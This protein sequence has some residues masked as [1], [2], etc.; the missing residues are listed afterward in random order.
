MKFY[1][2]K[3]AKQSNLFH[4]KLER[5][6]RSLTDYFLLLLNR[7][8]L[9]KSKNAVWTLEKKLKVEETIAL[10]ASYQGYNHAINRL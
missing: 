8:Y 5:L 10:N 2:C 1:L 7:R 6:L 9:L 3:A 4:G